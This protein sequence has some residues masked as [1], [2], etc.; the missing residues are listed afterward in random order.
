MRF[1]GLILSLAI[2]PFAFSGE[3]VTHSDLELM[4]VDGAKVK[5]S[6]FTDNSMEVTDGTHQVVVR[7]S[8]SFRDERLLQSRPYVFNIT[9]DGDTEISTNKLLSFAQAEQ[10]ISTELDWFVENDAGEYQVETSDQLH[11]DGFAPYADIEGLV[12]QYNQKNNLQV[13]EGTVTKI[14]TNSL[15][16]QYKAAT[17][18]QKKQF[19]IWLINNDIK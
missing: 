6:F 10:K 2:S 3:I 7:Y 13:T 1:T 4:A 9:V 15:I 11:G 8:N 5:S 12:G 14:T 19:K 16:E 17:A 18:E